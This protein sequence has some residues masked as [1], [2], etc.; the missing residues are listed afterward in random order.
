M[1]QIKFITK[2]ERPT[3]TGVITPPAASPDTI[4]GLIG[5]DL[6]V[7]TPGI[8]A[9][10]VHNT[11][12]LAHIAL[13]KVTNWLKNNAQLTIYSVDETPLILSFI[14]IVE[15]DIALATL[16]TGINS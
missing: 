2:K 1:A 7:L 11:T 12:Q 9:S 14:S 15:A 6:L 5:V 13:N 8:S 10:I 16:Q 4:S 3:G